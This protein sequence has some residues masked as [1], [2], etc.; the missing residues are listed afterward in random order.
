MGI[1]LFTKIYGVLLDDANESVKGKDNYYIYHCEFYSKR[2]N[3]TWHFLTW[4]APPYKEGYLKKVRGEWFVYSDG[5]N[6]R[7][8]LSKACV[9][10]LNIEGR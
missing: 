10:L 8:K 4:S 6:Y 3:G 9:D 1:R 2:K 5:G 7:W